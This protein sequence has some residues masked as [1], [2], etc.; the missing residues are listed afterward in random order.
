[1]WLKESFSDLFSR[2]YLSEKVN[3][4][5]KH[6]DFVNNEL[7]RAMRFDGGPDTHAMENHVKTASAVG[8]IYTDIPYRKGASIMNMVRIVLSD[9][10]FKE[11]LES[12]FVEK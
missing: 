8:E 10:I 2:L 7:Q 5:Y 11:G 4:G 1:M 9:S 6:E 12:L 3:V